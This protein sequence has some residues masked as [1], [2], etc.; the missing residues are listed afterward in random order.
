MWILHSCATSEQVLR[1]VTSHV[2]VH[3][4]LVRHLSDS[5]CILHANYVYGQVPAIGQN[6]V[7]T[8]SL[9]VSYIFSFFHYAKSGWWV[10]FGGWVLFHNTMVA[11]QNW[12]I[13]IGM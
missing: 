13:R 1:V 4:D 6:S 11:R 2:Q 5:K 12:S 8:L 10:F 7:D 3:V 9:S